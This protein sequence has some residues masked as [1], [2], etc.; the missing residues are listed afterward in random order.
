MI[1]TMPL[2]LLVDDDDCFAAALASVL[3][4]AGYKLLR[5]GDGKAALRL[6]DPQTVSLVLTDLVMPE[7]EGMDLISRL[8]QQHP[9]VKII[10][11]SGGEIN[12]AKSYLRAARLVG[13]DYI[14][15]KPFSKAQLLMAIHQGLPP[16]PV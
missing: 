6:Y 16:M 5:A 12:F 1:E 7:M 10:A 8:R 9:D 13:A 15:E 2:I 3:E 14:L 11:M 4:Q